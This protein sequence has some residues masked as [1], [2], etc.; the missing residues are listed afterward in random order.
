MKDKKLTDSEIVKVLKC[1]VNEECPDCER[2]SY[3]DYC[4]KNR[5]YI[6]VLDLINRL[7][8]ENE[9][10]KALN[11]RLVVLADR[12]RL[13]LKTAKAEACKEFVER[14]KE[15]VFRADSHEDG[16]EHNAVDIDDVYDLLKEFVGE[17][18]E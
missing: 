4:R 1:F 10:V 11:G 12:F 2:C 17:D 5:V 8:I 3:Y 18:N 9:T 7:Q 13:E 6:D 16:F 15:Y 14:L